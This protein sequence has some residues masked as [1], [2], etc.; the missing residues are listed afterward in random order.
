MVIVAKPIIRFID[1]ETPSIKYK[2]DLFNKLTVKA[3]K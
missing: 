1:E 3:N 2:L